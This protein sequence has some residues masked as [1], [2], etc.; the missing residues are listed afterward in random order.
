LTS[1]LLAKESK[2]SSISTASETVETFLKAS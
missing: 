2:F 1:G